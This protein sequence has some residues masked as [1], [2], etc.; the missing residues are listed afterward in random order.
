M[1]L[2]GRA[3][4]TAVTS[5]LDPVARTQQCA[6]QVVAYRGA[7][8]PGRLDRSIKVNVDANPA[9]AKQI[10]QILGGDIAAGAR[11]ERAAAQAA[12]R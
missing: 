1:L 2:S 4:S 6:G 9:V 7:G 11:R 10:H 8:D 5:A 12:D 3:M